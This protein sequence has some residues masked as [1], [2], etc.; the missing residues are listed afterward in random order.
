V[1]EELGRGFTL[2]ALDAAE[3]AVTAFVDAAATAGIPLTVVRDSASGELVDYGAR[4]ALVRPDQFVAWTGDVPPTD[5]DG[6][7][8]TVTG[9]A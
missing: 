9:R 2:L 6:L 1:F 3:S 7:L 8:A 4:L 5:V